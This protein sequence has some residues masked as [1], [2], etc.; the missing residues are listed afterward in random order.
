MMTNNNYKTKM[1]NVYKMINLYNKI[2]NSITDIN[3]YYFKSFM[4]IKKIVK[5]VSQNE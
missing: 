1:N 5:K 2:I 3:L 4:I